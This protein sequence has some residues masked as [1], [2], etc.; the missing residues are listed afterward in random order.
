MGTGKSAPV[1]EPDPTIEYSVVPGCYAKLAYDEQ[2]R[3]SYSEQGVRLKYVVLQKGDNEFLGA[4]V[5]SERR[6]IIIARIVNGGLA[7]KTALLHEGDEL[8]SA[9]GIELLGKDLNTVTEILGS[10]RGQVVLLVA[11]SA[12]PY[13]KAPRGGII[14]LRALFTYEPEEDRYLACQE[15]GLPFI[16]GDLVH[17][18]GR[19]DP[20]WWQAY[21]SDDDNGLTG[22]VGTLA[23]LIPSPIYQRQRAILRLQYWLDHGTEDIELE[24]EP[25]DTENVG[26]D[27]D[28][29]SVQSPEGTDKKSTGK[30]F[31]GMKLSF[32]DKRNKPARSKTDTV[33]T[34]TPAPPAPTQ[35][36][37]ENATTASTTEDED[38]RAPC[39]INSALLSSIYAGRLS[40][41]TKPSTQL[42]EGA[43]DEWSAAGP[44][45]GQHGYEA[46]SA[47]GTGHRRRR[48]GRKSSN[49]SVGTC[50]PGVRGKK[51]GQHQY[52]PSLAPVPDASLQNEED[53]VAW[54]DQEV[55]HGFMRHPSLWTYEPV[56]QYL[57]QP[58]RRRPLIF[59]GPAH[60]GRH[61][62]MQRLIQED[63]DRFC[64]AAI[65]MF[66][67]TITICCITTC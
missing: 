31:L 28:S 36:G 14:H 27:T 52:F 58:L 46:R 67:P 32:L 33:S 41:H 18:T 17:V 1:A 49:K 20:N 44:V 50:L 43:M 9:N 64:P 16:K 6:S 53:P 55:K 54:L 30:R 59:V 42:T 10:L 5:R 3:D 4:T 62:L 7:Q 8:L 61:Q 29:L 24:E 11:P 22:A 45:W 35:P 48:L 39:L 12:D 40:G 37:T 23:G 19:N 66:L 57:P 15:L 25:S 21:R 63:P 13:S 26:P 47:R 38:D 56:A 51:V 34:T 60:V 65:R 2:G